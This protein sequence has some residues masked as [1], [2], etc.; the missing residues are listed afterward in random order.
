MSAPAPHPSPIK[1]EKPRDRLALYL[2]AR[3]QLKHCQEFIRDIDAGR[4][5]AERTFPLLCN[6]AYRLAATTYELAGRPALAEAVRLASFHL[7]DANP[8]RD[9]PEE[10]THS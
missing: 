1:S 8:D 5:D 4:A 7:T 6:A 2:L 9:I 10:D 3:E